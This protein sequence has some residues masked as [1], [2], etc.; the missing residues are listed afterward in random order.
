MLRATHGCFRDFT[1]FAVF[2]VL[3]GSLQQSGYGQQ[4]APLDFDSESAT[5]PQN[6]PAG[7]AVVLVT[8]GGVKSQP[9]VTVAVR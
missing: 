2:L 4:P 5:V 8:I 6:I 9:G 3:F 1:C 7:D